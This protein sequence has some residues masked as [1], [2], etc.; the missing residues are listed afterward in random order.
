MNKQ[1]IENNFLRISVQET[2]AELCSIQSVKTGKEYMWQGNP[3]I[4][5]SYAPVLFPIVGEL[6][7]GT[8]HHE[9]VSYQ[10][11][12]HGFVRHN[13]SVKVMGKTDSSICMGLDYDED[14]LLMYPFRFQFRITFSLE[15]NKVVI[16]HEITNRG[17]ETMLF[18]VGGHPGFACPREADESYEDYYLEFS[19]KETL[20]RWRLTDK[21]LLS[22]QTEAVLQ[23]SAM[24]PLR[25]ELFKEDALIFKNP[26]SSKI[27]L[28]SKKS[29]DVL[30]VDYEDFSYLGIWAKPDGDYVC[31]EPWL[32]VADSHDS[33]QQLKDK[34]AILRLNTKETFTATYSIEI[35]EGNK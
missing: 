15:E 4:W 27:S 2:G 20:S 35:Q 28:K 25:H 31:I 16:R 12:R 33:D 26:K 21:G 19:E 13:S 29:A 6:K 1:T 8:Y 14:T 3:D 22:G 7:D 30:T 32:G 23:E 34:E 11:P 5:P 18:S 24:L 17:E 9:G 10:L